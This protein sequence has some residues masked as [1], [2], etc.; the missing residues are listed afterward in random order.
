M[1]DDNDVI[2]SIFKKDYSEKIK[3]HKSLK[4]MQSHILKELKTNET[5]K[6]EL[7]DINHKQT[8]QNEKHNTEKNLS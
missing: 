3:A 1:E 8:Q 4:E 6:K 5:L 7:N 2:S